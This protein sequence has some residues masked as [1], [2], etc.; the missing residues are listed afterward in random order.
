MKQLSVTQQW[1][2][3]TLTGMPGG[4]RA[5]M[6]L[7]E[8]R[9]WREYGEALALAMQESTAYSLNMTRPVMVTRSV[10]LAATHPSTVF[11]LSGTMRSAEMFKC[12]SCHWVARWTDGPSRDAGDEADQFW[13]QRCGTAT[14]L[15]A[16]DAERLA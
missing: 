15:T 11:Y 10:T 16:Y 7:I 2:D 5:A 8:N 1:P 4:R 9:M 14:N 6:I 12:P 3:A 13:C